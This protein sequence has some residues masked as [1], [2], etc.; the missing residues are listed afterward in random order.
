MRVTV[1][2]YWTFYFS[3]LKFWSNCFVW[4]NENIILYVFV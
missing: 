3:F 2:G 4:K 1:K